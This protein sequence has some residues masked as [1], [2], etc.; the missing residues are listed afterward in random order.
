[1]A[2]AIALR[3][4]YES[5]QLRGFCHEAVQQTEQWPAEPDAISERRD[6]ARVLSCA[7]NSVCEIWLRCS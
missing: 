5:T 7:T 2:A 3:D 4:D 1:M 6:R